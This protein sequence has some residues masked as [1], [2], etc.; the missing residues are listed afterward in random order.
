MT[1]T[2]I[3]AI[4]DAP[5]AGSSKECSIELPL[6]LLGFESIK[7]FTLTASAEEA[8]FQWLQMVD[9]PRHSFVVVEPASIV[10]DYH[11]NL[12]DEDVQFLRLQDPDDALVLNIVTLRAGGRP[13]MNL[14]GPIVINR[15]TFIG[16]QVIPLNASRFPLQHPLPAAL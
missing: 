14:K 9:A 5:E 15:R 10:A 12:S 1:T 11:P 6:G 4:T 16:K 3:T 7:Q 2:E 8:P 13:T